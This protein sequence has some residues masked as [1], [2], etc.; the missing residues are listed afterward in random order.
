MNIAV[1]LNKEVKTNP[2]LTNETI[3]ALIEAGILNPKES[4]NLLGGAEFLFVGQDKDLAAGNAKI[5]EH[6]KAIEEFTKT[7]NAKIE[8]KSEEDLSE[9]DKRLLK[10]LEANIEAEKTAIEKI[11]AGQK[12]VRDKFAALVAQTRTRLGK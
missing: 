5:E 12:A 2:A 1:I 7:Y 4:K 3:N 11:K 9:S 10:T 6:N 8:G